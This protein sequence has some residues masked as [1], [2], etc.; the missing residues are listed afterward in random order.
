MDEMKSRSTSSAIQQQ[1]DDKP[2]V[3]FMIRDADLHMEC[4]GLM[5]SIL[6]LHLIG[7]RFKTL[8]HTPVALN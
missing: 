3:V 6:G 4:R 5:R 7:F 1:P 8:R 2:L